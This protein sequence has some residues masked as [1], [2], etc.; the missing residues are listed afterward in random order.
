MWDY[1]DGDWWI[2]M[3]IWMA[4]FWTLLI[5]GALTVANWFAEAAKR[6][7]SPDETLDR[8]LASGE[9]DHAQY[10]A[11]REELQNRP[12]NPIAPAH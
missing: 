8:R 12:G 5:V 3:W 2:L 1:H 7:E 4:V 6:R 9:I 11:V 10:R